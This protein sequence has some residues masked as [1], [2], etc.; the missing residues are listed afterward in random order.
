MKL[1]AGLIAV[2]LL[3]SCSLWQPFDNYF[4]LLPDISNPQEAND[5]CYENI[6]YKTRPERIWKTPPNNIREGQ[7]LCRDYAI[8]MMFILKKQ[9]INCKY[10]SIKIN[11]TYLHA[12]IECGGVYYDPTNEKGL[13]SLWNFKEYPIID[14]YTFQEVHNFIRRDNL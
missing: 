4:D 11:D 1:L 7:G 9:D 10:I 8:V 6:K 12:L 3:F 14:I 5:W 2:L 13:T